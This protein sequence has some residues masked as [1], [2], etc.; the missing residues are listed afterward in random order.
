[1]GLNLMPVET[2]SAPTELEERCA[3]DD[4]APYI[5]FLVLAV[6]DEAINVALFCHLH[7]VLIVGI[8]E[9]KGIV[10][11][12]EIIELSLGCLNA[13][14]TTE[15]L[16]VGTTYI[17]NHTASRLHVCNEFLDVAWVGGSHLYDGY[18]MF[19]AQTEEGLRY[20]HIIIEVALC[21][22]HVVFLAQYGRNQ[23][24]GGGLAVGTSDTYHWDVEVA[25]MLT[26]QFLDCLLYTS[27]SPRD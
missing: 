23:F 3:R 25:A 17:R 6:S 12:K 4:F 24:L 19:A 13:L 16:Q 7:Q 14:E 18:L 20:A 15:A 26:S 27:P 1:M 21:E 2:L 10:G 5:A 11:R 22:H 8:D 9:Y